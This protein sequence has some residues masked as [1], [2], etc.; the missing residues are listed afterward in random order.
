MRKKL[1]SISEEDLLLLSQIKGERNLNNDSETLRFVLHDYQKMVEEKREHNI[2]NAILCSIESMERRILDGMNT[3]LIL[4]GAEEC[5]PAEYMESP[6]FT[7]SRE[8]EKKMIAN[9]KQKK[10]FKQKKTN[11]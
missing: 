2:S 8:Y 3:L 7:K 4:Q 6:V 1:F 9:E 10:D 11:R 5:F